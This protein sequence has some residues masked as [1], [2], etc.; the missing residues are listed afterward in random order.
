MK[1]ARYSNYIEKVGYCNPRRK[2]LKFNW[3]RI[4]HWIL[5]KLNLPILWLK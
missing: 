2:E 4:E 5:K 1:K 3:D